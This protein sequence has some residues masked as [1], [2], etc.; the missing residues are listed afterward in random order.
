VFLDISFHLKFAGSSMKSIGNSIDSKKMKR[1]K[2]FI[3]DVSLD[4]PAS[5]WVSFS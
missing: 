1:A 3:V 4:M 5:R 2:F